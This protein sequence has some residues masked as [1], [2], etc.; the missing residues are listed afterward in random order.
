LSSSA[1]REIPLATPGGD[2]KR[3]KSSECPAPQNE[4]P[5]KEQQIAAALQ[6]KGFRQGLVRGKSY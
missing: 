1:F 4:K 5:E 6:E 3:C 2:D